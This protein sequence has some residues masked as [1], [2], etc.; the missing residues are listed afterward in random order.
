TGGASGIGR[1]VCSRL[2]SEGA[3]VA[4]ADLDGPG[5]TKTV[6]GLPT[7]TP[8][9][10]ERGGGAGVAAGDPPHAAF[11]VDVADAD[12]VR[13]LLEQIQLRFGAPPNVCV[14]CAGVTRD[15]FL[16]QLDTGSYETVLGVNLKGTFLVTQAVARALVAAG[17][18][19]SIIHMGSI[20]GKVGNLGQTHYA[21]SKGGVESLT[22]SCAKELAR[23][24]IRCNVVLPGFIVTPM[25]HKVPPKVLEKVRG[26][27][28]MV[29]LGRLGEPEDVADVCA[30]LAS[31]D[32]SYLTGA[33]ME[34]TGG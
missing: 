32:S 28:G 7:P 34:V 17:A 16:L 22:R 25:T 8:S 3:R 5:A 27:T 29:P 4:V 12:S 6:Q 2:A 26:V 13:G 23:Y 20:V 14:A 30:F 15:Q 10:Q 21:A 33:S 9:T 19:G 1:A 31:P 11:T 24:G 18:P